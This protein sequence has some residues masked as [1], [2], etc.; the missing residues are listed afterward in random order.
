MTGGFSINMVLS[1]KTMAYATATIKKY[2]NNFM[3]LTLKGSKNLAF[4]FGLAFNWT[5]ASFVK[6]NPS[7]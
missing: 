6:V 2:S 5:K 3:F 4:Q 1:A 7:Y